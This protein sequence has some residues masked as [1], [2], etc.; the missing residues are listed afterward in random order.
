MPNRDGTG[1]NGQGSMSGR[2]KGNCQNNST[3]DNSTNNSIMGVGKGG[4]PNGGGKGRCAGG[5]NKGKNQ[6]L[7]N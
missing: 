1:P 4:K 3:V 6:N 5:R 2:R 7:S